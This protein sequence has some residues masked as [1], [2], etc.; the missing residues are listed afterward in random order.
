MN[1]I[2]GITGELLILVPLLPL[3]S[4]LDVPT[5]GKKNYQGH[6][7]YIIHGN[8][9]VSL[10]VLLDKV[11]ALPFPFSA[12]SQSNRAHRLLLHVL[13]P[14]TSLWSSLKL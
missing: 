7:M 8:F 1:A 14:V 13:A 3:S 6:R 5:A 2:T 9:R 10:L 4:F 12:C 11:L